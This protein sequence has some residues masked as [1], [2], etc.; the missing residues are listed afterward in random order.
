[1]GL[2]EIVD[3]YRSNGF[4]DVYLLQEVTTQPY[5]DE[6]HAEIEKASGR[7][8]DGVYSPR[9]NVAVLSVYPIIE[10]EPFGPEAARWN[11]GILRALIDT[12]A[13]PLQTI[14]VHL[15]PILKKRDAAG[16]ATFWFSLAG[17]AWDMVVPNRRSLAVAEM[18]RWL[19]QYEK[20]P[21]VLGGDFNTIPLTAAIRRMGL[22]YTDALLGSG[23]YFVGTYW[24]ISSPIRPRVDFIFHSRQ[25]T[26]L[27]AAVLPISTGDHLPVTATIALPKD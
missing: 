16:F 13:G 24:K 18:R 1:V 20:G 14:S 2:S 9:F 23:Q 4:S 8:Y 3:E 17:L 5:F 27:D 11:N 15:D 10:S 19:R 12:P 22:K 26:V 7:K 6:L 21:I 25:I